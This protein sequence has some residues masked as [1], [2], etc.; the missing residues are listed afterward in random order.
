MTMPWCKQRGV[1]N[2]LIVVSCLRAGGPVEAKRCLLSQ[3]TRPFIRNYRRFG[4]GNFASASHVSRSVVGRFRKSRIR[5]R[6]PGR[7][8][9]R[10]FGK[11]TSHFGRRIFSSPLPDKFPFPAPDRAN[12]RAWDRSRAFRRRPLRHFVGGRTCCEFLN[13]EA[14]RLSFVVSS[15]RDGLVRRA[16]RQNLA[17]VARS[18][19]IQAALARVFASQPLFFGEQ[20][21]RALVASV[22]VKYS[23][24]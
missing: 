19:S 4:S 8:K 3:S 11:A 14:C 5:L 16:N 2:W 17:R 13:F 6:P 10:T 9:P 15:F 21:P 7:H 20:R 18:P 24:G 12:F 22:L 1:E 23:R